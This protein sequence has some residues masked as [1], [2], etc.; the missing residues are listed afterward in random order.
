MQYMKRFSADA[1]RSLLNEHR[2]AELFDIKV[3]TL[4]KW[5]WSGDGP[6]FIKIGAAVRYDPETLRAFIDAGRRRSTSERGGAV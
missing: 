1:T 5:R 6:E 4:R 3:S 2:T